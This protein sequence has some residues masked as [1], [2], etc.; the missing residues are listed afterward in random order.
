[1]RIEAE[2]VCPLHGETL[3]E[4]RA[5]R[6]NEYRT[7]EP[8]PCCTTQKDQGGTEILRLEYV[9][10]TLR[11]LPPPRCRRLGFLILLSGH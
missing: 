7:R 3:H 11:F 5:T 8:A 2:K 10:L 6:S 9:A 1:L 4:Q